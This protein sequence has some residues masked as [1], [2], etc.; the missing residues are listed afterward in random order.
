MRVPEV[1]ISDEPAEVLHLRRCFDPACN[2][3]FTVCA[4]CD[5]GQRYCSGACR[6]RMRRQQLVAAGR[7][8]QASDA[9]KQAHRRR[10]QAYRCRRN[11]ASVTH[12]G[13]VSITNSSPLQRPS[14]NKCLICGRQSRWI[15]PFTLNWLPRARRRHRRVRRLPTDVQKNTFS[16]DR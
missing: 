9:G 6:K 12:Q 2:A 11:P 4:H 10:Q 15:N 16:D 8:Y 5:R 1:T 14:L 13:R 7:R 3:L